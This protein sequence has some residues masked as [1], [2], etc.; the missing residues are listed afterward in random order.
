MLTLFRT[1]AFGVAI[2]TA[3]PAVAYDAAPLIEDL[4]QVKSI[5]TSNHYANLEWLIGEREADLDAVFQVGEQRLAAAA[6]EAEAKA[7]FER[8]VVNLGDGHLRVKWSADRTALHAGD[9]GRPCGDM[10]KVTPIQ[11]IAARIPGWRPVDGEAAADFPAG[12]VESGGR[13]VGV[14]KITLFMADPAVCEAAAKKLNLPLDKPCDEACG[15]E[16]DRETYQVL[17]DRLASR[18]RDLKAAGAEVLMIDLAGNG[19][20]REWAEVVARMVTAKPVKGA[21]VDLVRTETTAKVLEQRA[22]DL[23]GYARK[24]RGADR[25]LLSKTASDLRA[26]AA[27]ARRACDA[28]PFLKREASGCAW[29]VKGGYSTGLV[30]TLDPALADR[31]WAADLYSPAKIKHEA[32]LWSG[33]L[34]VLVDNGSASASEELTA[35]LQDA[36]AAVILGSPTFGAG[37]GHSTPAKPIALKNSG[38]FLSLPDCARLR[39]DG[40][41]EIMGV[42]P[43]ILIGLRRTDGDVRKAKRLEAKLPEA[44]AAAIR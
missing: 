31:P 20:G 5:L 30:D 34:I 12:V 43:D 4:R 28:T 6:N 19:G 3:A 32:G 15:N 16:L 41:N 1:V 24:A 2:S 37:C 21:R 13:K 36:R 8:T 25:A 14:L 17:T 38:G 33:P 23:E 35:E 40:S 7:Q 42:E 10:G 11:P 9:S 44:V 39:A 18:L 27:E 22:A 29:L 26:T